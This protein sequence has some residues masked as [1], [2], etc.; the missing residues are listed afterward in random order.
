M[1]PLQHTSIPAMMHMTSY[2]YLDKRWKLEA[3]VTVKPFGLKH[4]ADFEANFKNTI[5]FFIWF[6]ES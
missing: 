5:I 4:Y 1:E 6:Y 3:W 2:Q